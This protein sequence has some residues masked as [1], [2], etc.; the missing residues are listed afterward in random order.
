MAF[1][2]GESGNPKGRSRGTPN[3]QT[4][5]IK[6]MIIGALE[7]K[8]GVKYL[9]RQAEENPVAFMGLVGKVLPLQLTGADGGAIE[10]R[11]IE[12]RVVPVPAQPLKLVSNASA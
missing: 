12:R 11:A 1:K 8:G 9:M 3:K 4:A 2:K 6:D 5:A 10:I 7:A